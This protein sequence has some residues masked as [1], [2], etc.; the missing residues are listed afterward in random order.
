MTGDTTDLLTWFTTPSHQN[1]KTVKNIFYYK[2]KR[3]IST[4]DISECLILEIANSPNRECLP[5]NAL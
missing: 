3:V 1:L 5:E 2:K 4:N